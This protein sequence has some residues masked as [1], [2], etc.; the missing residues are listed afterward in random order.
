MTGQLLVRLSGQGAHL[1]D[2]DVPGGG[3]DEPG[4]HG[5]PGRLATRGGRADLG[6][7]LFD[8]RRARDGGEPSDEGGVALGHGAFVQRGP[9]VVQGGLGRDGGVAR[10]RRVEAVEGECGFGEPSQIGVAGT[11]PRRHGVPHRV[12]RGNGLVEGR[13]GVVQQPPGIAVTG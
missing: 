10:Q 1:V 5:Q 13:L 7:D 9:H 6:Q 8:R 11:A 12:G 4:Q 2:V 3:V